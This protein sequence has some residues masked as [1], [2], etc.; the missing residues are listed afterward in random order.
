M[1]TRTARRNAAVRTITINNSCTN[2]FFIALLLPD[3]KS[4]MLW[5]AKYNQQAGSI[6][7]L[8]SVVILV[9]PSVRSSWIFRFEIR[10][11]DGSIFIVLRKH[12]PADVLHIQSALSFFPV[13]VGG[14]HR[15]FKRYK[16]AVINNCLLLCHYK[17][18]LVLS[19]ANTKPTNIMPSRSTR[20]SPQ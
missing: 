3:K 15:C 1:S 20:S 6:S 19:Q 13:V 11:R 2:E 7:I 14:W 4:H 16:V 9:R 17:L 12:R 8:S 5:V 18:F 10:F